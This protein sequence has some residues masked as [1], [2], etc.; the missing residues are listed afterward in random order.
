MVI[1]I[2][3][4]KGGVGKT[5][6]AINLATALA[7]RVNFRVLLVDFD[8]QANATSGLGV[9]KTTLKAS[10]YNFLEAGNSEL[11]IL[12]TRVKNLYLMPSSISLSGAEIELIQGQDREFRLKARLEEN[13]SSE[14]PIVIIDT[15]PS[16]GM[17]TLNALVASQKVII[18]I[19]CEYYA[20]EGLVDFFNTLVLIRQ[21][22][23]PELEILGV[24]LTMADYRT[25]IAHDVEE[26][27]RNK[28]GAKVFHT[29]IHR[30]VRLAEAPSYG[31]PIQ[32]YDSRSVGAYCYNALAEEVLNL[33]DWNGEKEGIGERAFSSDT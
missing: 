5:T 2:S 10:V 9:E 7:L 24:L 1:S 11:P 26:E 21:R 8:P 29:V 27:I 23:N 12:E 3:N 6:T 28:F 32:L 20:L 18:P 13:V 17:L 30:N 4:Q 33:G 19:Q 25:R 14:Y 15:P 22:L 31:L 16:L